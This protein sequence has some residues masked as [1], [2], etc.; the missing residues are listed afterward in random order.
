LC[1]DKCSDHGKVEDGS[2]GGKKERGMGWKW[3][4]GWNVARAMVLG[5]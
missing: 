1:R 3:R 2:T 5:A 4:A